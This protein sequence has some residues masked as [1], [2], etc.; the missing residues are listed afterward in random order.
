MEDFA[1]YWLVAMRKCDFKTLELCLPENQ[2]MVV[3]M[4]EADRKYIMKDNFDNYQKN[5]DASTGAMAV[6]KVDN[7]TLC[8]VLVVCANPPGI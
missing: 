7:M 5:F 2:S 6:C 4:E 3:L 8:T 1:T